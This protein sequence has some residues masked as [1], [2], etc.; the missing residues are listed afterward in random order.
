MLLSAIRLSVSSYKTAGIRL[1]SCVL[2]SHDSMGLPMLSTSVRVLI[3]L[4]VI[5]CGFVYFAVG[6]L[7]ILGVLCYARLGDIRSG[8]L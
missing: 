7:D 1:L 3:R 2:P 6:V 4:R 8:H 5:V